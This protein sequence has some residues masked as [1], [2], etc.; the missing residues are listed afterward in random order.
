MAFVDALLARDL[1][2]IGQEALQHIQALYH[3]D[4]L[5]HAAGELS[6][7]DVVQTRLEARLAQ[8]DY[9]ALLVQYA[10]ALVQLDLLMGGD[11]GGTRAVQG[12]MAAPARLFDLQQLLEGADTLRMDLVQQ[13]HLALSA[14]S[15]LTLLRR[16]RMPDLDLSLGVS[17][18][19]RVRN[20]EAPAPEFV[21]YTVGVGIPL[22][23]SNLN[24]GE[25]RSGQYRVQQARLQDTLCRR[26]A[27][28]EI[29]Q[30]Y[31]SYQS[32]L[33]RL[34]GYN[35]LIMDNARQ[36]LDGKMYAYQR[37]ETSLLDVISAQ[38]TYNEIRQAYAECLHDCLAAWVELERSAGLWDISL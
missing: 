17:L 29:M 15:D 33:R 26:Q 7:I 25:V 1:T 28:S 9:D 23:L 11:L 14:E 3:S 4:S 24:R 12:T 37:G 16:E 21:G 5:R 36:V 30:A 31:N 13:H 19:S 18:N 22:P 8:Q 2:L 35:T 20:E 6:E 32:A 38:H 34:A 27:R 10:N